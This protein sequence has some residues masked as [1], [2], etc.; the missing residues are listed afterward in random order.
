MIGL[1]SIDLELSVRSRPD[2]DSHDLTLHL[3]ARAFSGLI[4]SSGI[5]K[6]ARI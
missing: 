2:S 6:A 5:P 4:E 3:K 1:A